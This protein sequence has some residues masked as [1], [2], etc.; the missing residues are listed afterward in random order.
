VCSS[1]TYRYS[2][3]EEVEP[4][5]VEMKQKN[6]VPD[7]SVYGLLVDLWGKAGN[8]EKASEWYRVMLNEGLL[9]NIPTCN[10]FLCDNL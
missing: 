5:F 3:L 1:G 7:E 8:V 4:V 6:W 10:S 9:P 2:Y